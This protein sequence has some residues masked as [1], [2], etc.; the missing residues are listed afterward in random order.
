M[1]R[2]LLTGFQEK[3]SGK[4]AST[5]TDYLQSSNIEFIQH[6]LGFLHAELGQYEETIFRLHYWKHE[7]QNLGSA[8]TP[9]HDHIWSLSSCI[10]SGKIKNSILKIHPSREGRYILTDVLQNN[11]IDEVKTDGIRASFEV[12]NEVTYDVGEFY[13]LKPRVFHYSSLVGKIDAVTI[14]LSEPAVI[15]SPRTLMPINSHGHAPERKKIKNSSPIRHEIVELLKN[16]HAK[17]INCA[18]LLL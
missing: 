6:P 3:D 11:N 15:G 17:K 10:L 18:D 5:I 7:L 14:V 8:I 9:Y 16:N 13:Y 2:Q 4:L 12:V 1:T